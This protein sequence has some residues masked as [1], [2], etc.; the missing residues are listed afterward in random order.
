MNAT[1]IRILVS[2]FLVLA[3]WRVF[4]LPGVATAF[5][6]FCTVGAIPGSDRILGTEAVLR[7][8]CIVFALCFFLIFRKEF[9][10]SLPRRAPKVKP[11]V[12]ASTSIG[13]SA[14][15]VPVA[16][17]TARDRIVVVISK[18]QNRPALAPVRPLVV[19]LGKTA[20]WIVQ[21][22]CWVEADC[23]RF[24]RFVARQ[25]RRLHG[26]TSHFIATVVAAVYR[27]IKAIVRYVVFAAIIA[28]KLAEPHI[29]NFDRWLDKQLHA[30]RSTSEVLQFM[31]DVTKAITNAYHHAEQSSRKLRE[32]K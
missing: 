6:A 20:A 1:H 23:R 3:I 11:V 29:R 4:E 28:W 26:V 9:M 5:W 2:V 25:S 19:I 32:N 17:P 13:I 22:T 7:G 31:S 10:A 27:I 12:P 24:G 18:Q 14:V 8:L 30:N 16:V 21:L 15:P